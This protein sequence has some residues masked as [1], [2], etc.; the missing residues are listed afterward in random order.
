MVGEYGIVDEH[1]LTKR[2]D[3]YTLQP[4]VL[5]HSD[6]RRNFLSSTSG[7]RIDFKRFVIPT[8]EEIF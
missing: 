4:K 3:L 1:S 5:C 2:I 8:A 7:K 6:G